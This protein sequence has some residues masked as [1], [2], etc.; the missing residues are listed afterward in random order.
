MRKFPAILCWRAELLWAS[1]LVKWGERNAS[2][3]EGM[4]NSAFF[5]SLIHQCFSTGEIPTFWNS[6]EAVYLDLNICSPVR[7]ARLTEPGL[8]VWRIP[9]SLGA[10]QLVRQYLVF[11]YL[12]SIVH[13][14]ISLLLI[15]RFFILWAERSTRNTQYGQSHRGFSH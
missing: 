11:S 2:C 8:T 5:F 4:Q 6:C 14:S 1:H 7:L 9:N 3:G 15:W 13:F 12:Q 10:F